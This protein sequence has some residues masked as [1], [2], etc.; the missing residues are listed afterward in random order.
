MNNVLGMILAGGEG[1]RL[2]PL[3]WDRAKPAVPFGGKYRIID[4]V[5]NNFINSEIYKIKILTQFKS[6]S[7]NQ[8]IAR[9]WPMPPIFGHF[10]DLVPAQMRTGGRWYEGTADAIYQN[11]NLI[12]DENPEY[13][14]VFGADHIY[15][16]DLRQML[17]FHQL[18]D[19]DLT[20]A[21]IPIP[22]DRASEFGIIQTNSGYSVT[23]WQEKPE[24][25]AEIPGQQ[26]VCLAS[27]GNYIFNKTILIDELNRD[28]EEDHSSHDFGKDIIQSMIRRGLKVCVYD[29]TQNS[30]PNIQ[31]QEVGYW[32]DVGTLA[33]YWE[34]SMDLLSVT[35]TFNMYN[36]YWPIRTYSY[37]APPAK[38]V[39]D[40][41]ERKGYATD[42]L[43]SDGCIISG[44][45][46]DKSILSP[47]VR[48]NSFAHVEESILMHGVNIG[49]HAQIRRAIIDKGVIIPAGVK[50]GFDP[51]ED[52]ARGFLVSPE[53]ITVLAKGT[54]IN[55]S[56]GHSSP[57]V[58]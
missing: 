29:F 51:E 45:R 39:F 21:A 20:I 38:F 43:V 9:G 33:S 34:A 19:A 42:S 6:D 3:T 46:I 41:E 25:P 44:G 35:P 13:V 16:M 4:F 49:R 26:G 50:I 18:M 14:A 17:A 53:G 31:T 22:K 27:M 24:H 56:L 40:Q 30:H 15:K 55:T 1:R 2:Y 37:H 47:Y 8:H 57:L 7:L 11:L 23:G 12:Y 5:L 32:R 10:I 52:R 48:V 58:S 54:V 36:P 28:A